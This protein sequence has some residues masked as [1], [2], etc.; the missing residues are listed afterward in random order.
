MRL[1]IAFFTL[2]VVA[3][4]A[5]GLE[6]REFR[7]ARDGD[8]FARGVALAAAAVFAVAIVLLTRIVARVDALR[9]AER[10]ASR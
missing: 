7:L 1:N 9:R 6:L 3:T 5:L 8:M 2:L 10:E 4:L